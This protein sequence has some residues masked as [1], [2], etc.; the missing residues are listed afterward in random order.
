MART[1]KRT[2]GAKRSRAKRTGRIKVTRN[3]VIFTLG[4]REIAKAKRCLEE[5]GEIRIAFKELRVTKLPAVLD[6][7]KLID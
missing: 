5:S 6:D 1:A 7:G 4:P 3:R 2:K